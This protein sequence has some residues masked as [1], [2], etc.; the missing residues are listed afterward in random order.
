MIDALSLYAKS[1]TASVV[2]VGALVASEAAAPVLQPWMYGG[3]AVAFL[4][5]IYGYGKLNGRIEA[6]DAA[7]ERIEKKLDAA[8]PQLAVA[9]D[10]T[11]GK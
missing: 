10:R 3:A 1:V 9:I 6:H 7:L 5:A 11:E 2:G 4:G 8:L